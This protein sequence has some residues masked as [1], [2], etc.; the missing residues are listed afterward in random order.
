MIKYINKFILVAVVFIMA[1]CQATEL[2]EL[3]ENPNGVAPENADV[4]FL[5]N[6]VQLDFA[7]FVNQ[8]SDLT[9]PVVRMMT[10]GG[11]VYENS[12]TPQSFNN[13]WTIAYAGLFPDICLLYTS[14][15][16]RDS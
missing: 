9:M 11:N 8:T 16:P 2:D 13:I 1:G 4:N 6:S 5:F 10:M 15:S 12:Y 14:P 3:L 7:Q